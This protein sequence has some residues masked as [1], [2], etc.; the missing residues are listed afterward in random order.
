MRTSILTT[1]PLF[2][3]AIALRAPMDFW[4][5]SSDGF[6]EFINRQQE[7]VRYLGNEKAKHTTSPLTDSH[8]LLHSIPLDSH[9][10]QARYLVELTNLHKR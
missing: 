6:L 1:Y 8:L 4:R 7:M 10:S 9:A 5:S 3:L 2:L